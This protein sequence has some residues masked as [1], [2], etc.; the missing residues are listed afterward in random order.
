MNM[1]SIVTALHNTMLQALDILNVYKNIY[2]CIC[3][4]I[5][6]ELGSMQET[7]ILCIFH[8]GRLI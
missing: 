8:L 4:C 6:E 3:V 2:T 1:R 5:P 7:I